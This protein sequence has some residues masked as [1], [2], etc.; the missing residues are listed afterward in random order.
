MH[1]S[2]QELISLRDGEPSDV[3]TAQHVAD[4]RQCSSELVRLTSLAMQL[5]Q[6][7][8]LQPPQRSWSA[9][10][11]KL[12]PPAPSN[13]RRAWLSLS[14]AAVSAVVALVLLWVTLQQHAA[15]YTSSS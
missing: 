15:I 11:G 12:K 10:K 3:N 9:I 4:C 5:R 6:L 8:T 1:A 7:P 14:A 13:R 2:V